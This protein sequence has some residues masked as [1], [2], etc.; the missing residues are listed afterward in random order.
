M[1]P[2]VGNWA[3]V[4]PTT[5]GLSGGSRCVLQ[6]AQVL[7]SSRAG[8]WWKEATYNT[9]IQTTGSYPI[10]G[11][12]GLLNLGAV[13]AKFRLQAV[14]E[15][16]RVCRPLSS[17]PPV[18]PSELIQLWMRL[19]VPNRQRLL[20]LLRQLLEHQLSAAALGGGQR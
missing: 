19:P 3:R 20:G 14:E 10:I 12:S 16:G 18:G 4:S 9:P 5:C 17:P 2:I 15:K 13:V 6:A 8:G 1:G 11:L 7:C